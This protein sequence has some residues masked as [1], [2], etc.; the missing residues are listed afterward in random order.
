MFET[1]AGAVSSS[2]L[3]KTSLRDYCTETPR[4]PLFVASCF[5]LYFSF[6]WLTQKLGHCNTNANL[7]LKA[8]LESN[9]TTGKFAR[10]CHLR[11]LKY[12]YDEK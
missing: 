12:N 3:M 7:M 4:C 9:R 8:T 11:K 10:I 6:C 1:F 2:W 5:S